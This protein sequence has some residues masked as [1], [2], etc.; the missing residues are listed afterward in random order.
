[1]PRVPDVDVTEE[2]PPPVIR[3]I[4]PP[5]SFAVLPKQSQLTFLAPCFF[6]CDVARSLT[7]EEVLER[8]SEWFI[9]RGTPD[10]IRSDNGPEFAAKRVRNWREK[11]DVKTLFMEPG[12]PWENGTIESFDGQLRDELLNVETFDT[13]L[14]ARVLTERWRIH[15]NTQRLHSS[16]GYK[17][18][19]PEAV[20]TTTQHYPITT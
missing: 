1:M 20:L 2:T 14:E 18:P 7:S 13:P 19:A 6:T 9:H 12:S 4:W 11:V 17:P 16:L 8:L 5:P 3:A 15:Y 10:F